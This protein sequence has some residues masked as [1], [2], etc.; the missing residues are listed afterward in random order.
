[1]WTAQKKGIS[2]RRLRS[3]QKFTGTSIAGDTWRAQHRIF[4]NL[5]SRAAKGYNMTHPA[6][7][8]G[9]FLRAAT[10]TSV[11]DTCYVTY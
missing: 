3:A 1:M 8:L 4:I 2:A 5:E 10:C 7:F 6:A 9:G 11:A